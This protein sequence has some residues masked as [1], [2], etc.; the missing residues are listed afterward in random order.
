[1]FRMLTGMCI[2]SPMLFHPQKKKHKYKCQKAAVPQTATWG[3]LSKQVDP[4]RPFVKFYSRN[5]HV[6]NQVQKGSL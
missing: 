4:Q 1:M 3:C 5:K 2:E 6:Y